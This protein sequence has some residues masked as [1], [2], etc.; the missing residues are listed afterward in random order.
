MF[1]AFVGGF[2]SLKVVKLEYFEFYKYVRGTIESFK[3]LK[4]VTKK[5]YTLETSKNR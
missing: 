3:N 4:D 1:I 5:F 2:E